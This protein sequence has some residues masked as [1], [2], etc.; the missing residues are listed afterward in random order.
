MAALLIPAET[1]NRTQFPGESLELPTAWDGVESVDATSA[2][3]WVILVIVIIIIIII[4]I[5]TI[6][7][8]LTVAPVWS[9][10]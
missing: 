1:L 9:L 6:C 2:I 8:S 4:I 10:T 5:I 3:N 7:K